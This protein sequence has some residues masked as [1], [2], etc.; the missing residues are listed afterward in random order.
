MECDSMLAAIASYEFDEG[1]AVH[2]AYPA[3]DMMSE[4]L[5]NLGLKY[6]RG[7]FKKAVALFPELKKSGYLARLARRCFG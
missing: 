1:C 2:E 4:E 7:Y 6:S 5:S 3:L